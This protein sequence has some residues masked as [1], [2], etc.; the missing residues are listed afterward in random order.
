VAT[1]ELPPLAPR[2]QLRPSEHT[3]VNANIGLARDV[4]EDA[5]RLALQPQIGFEHIDAVGAPR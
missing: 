4:F 2:L 5:A 3:L 1:R